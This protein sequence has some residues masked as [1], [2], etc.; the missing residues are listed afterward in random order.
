[1]NDR[2]ALLSAI[3]CLSDLSDFKRAGFI[4]NNDSVFDN[5]HRKNR[6]K[7]SIPAYVDKNAIYL[8]EMGK[9]KRKEFLCQT[10]R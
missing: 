10:L 3:C 7:E 1:V 4:F 2:A 8:R 5:A 6:K 9:E